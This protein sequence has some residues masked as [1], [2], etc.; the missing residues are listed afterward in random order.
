MSGFPSPGRCIQRDHPCVANGGPSLG[1]VVFNGCGWSLSRRQVPCASEPRN[2]ATLSTPS[3][4]LPRQ[5]FG[6]AEARVVKNEDFAHGQIR[7]CTF[8]GGR[9]T[10]AR[11]FV[12]IDDDRALQHF[13]VCVNPVR[14]RR[15]VI[16]AEPLSPASRKSSSPRR[17]S[18]DS[19]TPTRPAIRCNVA[20]SGGVW[21]YST[22]FG[23]MPFASMSS[24]RCPRFGASRVVVDRNTHGQ[25]CAVNQPE[26]G[27]TLTTIPALRQGADTCLTAR[28]GACNFA[29]CARQ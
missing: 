1:H 29:A 21:R 3:Q 28:S 18:S 5:C 17:I 27:A 12:F 4:T 9:P 2:P 14:E 10:T 26:I 25:T 15:F 11:L 24:Q 19:G 7:S 16:D 8:S 6:R 20:A 22:I 23:V 13:R